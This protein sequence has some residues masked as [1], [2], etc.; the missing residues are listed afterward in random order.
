MQVVDHCIV[1]YYYQNTLTRGTIGYSLI[2][3]DRI[4]LDLYNFVQ[5][6]KI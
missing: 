3:I 6:L 5:R 4:N 2:S 1:S